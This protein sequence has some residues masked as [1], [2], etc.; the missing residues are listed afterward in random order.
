MTDKT[1]LDEL[2]RADPAD[3]GC[4]E[5]MLVLDQYVELEIAGE[6]AAARFPGL[7]AHLRA[8]PAC[9]LDHDG[10]LQAATSAPA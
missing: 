5:G 10:L 1:T 4:D 9:L 8:C 2:L 7:A 3:C 6:E